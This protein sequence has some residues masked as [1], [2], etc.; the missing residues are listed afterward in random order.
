MLSCSSDGASAEAGPRCAYRRR[1]LR[2]FVRIEAD[3]ARGLDL[4]GYSPIAL[5]NPDDETAIAPGPRLIFM[6]TP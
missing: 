5:A 2:S 1:P 3:E 6:G 4:P